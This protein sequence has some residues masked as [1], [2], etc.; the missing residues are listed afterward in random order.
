QASTLEAIAASR[1]EVFY[2]G[3]IAGKIAAHAKA[4]GGAMTR[5]DLAAH[6]NDW[7]EPLH[8]DYRGLTVHELPPNG[9]GIVCL[10]ALGMLSNFDL[11]DHPVDS[12]DS[13]HLQIEAVKLAFADAYRRVADPQAMDLAPVRLLDP[14]YL[15][16]RARLID[17]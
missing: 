9:Q 15:K 13:V 14:D 7:V 17:R 2:R 1:G 11:A 10:M 5:E 8:Q 6:A 16:A 12:A 3:E 4:H